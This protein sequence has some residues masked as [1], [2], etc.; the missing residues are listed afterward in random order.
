MS[1][2]IVVV[3]SLLGPAC[4]GR[5]AAAPPAS[6]PEAPAAEAAVE[7]AQAPGP[8]AVAMAPPEAAPAGAASPGAC[9]NR[10]VSFTIARATGMGSYITTLSCSTSLY[11]VV[12]DRATPDG[13]EVK[14]AFQVGQADWEKAWKAVEDLRWRTLDDRCS[15]KESARGRGEGP[16]Y[17]ITIDDG[18][19]KRSF[20]CQGMRDLTAPLDAV[21]TEVLALEPPELQ[22]MPA[23]GVGVKECDDYLARYQKCVNEKVPAAK[24]QG[25][26]DAIRF[27]RQGLHETLMRNPDSGSALAKQCTEMIAAAR[28]AMASYKCKL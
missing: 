10:K 4:G 8:V 15:D 11:T 1:I 23:A 5:A 21:Q 3:L 12:S 13:R 18:S 2:R 6:V 25:F 20:T 27:T 9:G 14:S 19:N 24:R 26:L 17:R 7:E 16:V 22:A 28:A